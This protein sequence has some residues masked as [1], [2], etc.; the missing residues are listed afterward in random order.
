MAADERARDPEGGAARRRRVSA[1][2]VVAGPET[3]LAEIRRRAT[4]A[5]EDPFL[6]FRDPRGHFRW[7]SWG[8]VARTLERAAGCASGAAEPPG[9]EVP[10]EFLEILA[11]TDERAED[12]ARELVG[13]LGAGPER[14]VW[15]SFRRLDEVERTVAL[16]GLLGGWAI[17]REPVEPLPPATFAWARPTVLVAPAA[18]VAA[19]LDGLAGEAPRALGRRWLRRRLA[20]LRAVVVDDG[21]AAPAL[22]ERLGELGAPARV[23]PFREH[24]W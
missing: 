12:G 3:A 2:A 20:R 6:F 9:A 16:A 19:L 18:G 11:R 8:H 7:W 5:A 24:G 13:R 23:L 1:E 17:L 4:V 15:I 14:D 10:L 21:A 22:A